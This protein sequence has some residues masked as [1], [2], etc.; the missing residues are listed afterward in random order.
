MTDKRLCKEVERTLG[1]RIE[2]PQDFVW[3]S[4]EVAKSGKGTLSV[5]T[6]KR[7]WGY[8]DDG[9][10]TRRSTLDVLAQ[11]IGYRDYVALCKDQEER[12]NEIAR[13]EEVRKEENGKEER[14]EE[15][16]EEEAG[17]KGIK[18]RWIGALLAVVAAIAL[19]VGSFYLRNQPNDPVYVTD[20]SQLSQK[21]Q[22]YIHT[23]NKARGSL[24][25]SVS[26]DGNNFL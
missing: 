12:E 21:K 7:L 26:Y 10:A 14:L 25:G 1:R 9:H 4:E 5:N 15:I 22:Y 11:F 18:S 13:E 8:L 19:M 24:G 16:I 2:S 6:L 23:R 3:L 20:L 17:K